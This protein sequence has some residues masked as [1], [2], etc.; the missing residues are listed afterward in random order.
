[1]ELQ[2]AILLKVIEMALSKY[3]PYQIPMEKNITEIQYDPVL[4]KNTSQTDAPEGGQSSDPVQPDPVQPDPVQ[5]DPVQHDQA[6]PGTSS[7]S[8]TATPE[9][10]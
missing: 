1:M 6:Q 8:T 9:K 3:F 7:E 4:H 2:N 10:Y 5:L